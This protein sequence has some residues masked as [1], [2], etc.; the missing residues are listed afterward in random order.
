ML[1]VIGKVAAVPAARLIDPTA[2][3]TDHDETGAG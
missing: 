3:V 1:E 2:H